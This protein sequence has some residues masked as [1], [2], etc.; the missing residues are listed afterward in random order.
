MVETHGGWAIVALALAA[1]PGCGRGYSGPPTVPVKGRVV[2]DDGGDVKTLADRQTSVVFNSLDHPDLL[3]YGEIAED[4]TFT[5][6]TVKDRRSQP[7]AV[8]GT[9]RVRLYIDEG[10]ERFVS[11]RFGRF[12]TSGLTVQVASNQEIVLQLRKN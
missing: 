8:A 11:P 10:T 12:E 3:A 9:H 4:G 6:A 5:L 2:F 7:G 1:L